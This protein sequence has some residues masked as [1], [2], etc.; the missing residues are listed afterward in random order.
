MFNRAK[1][2]FFAILAITG[3]LALLSW[4]A[5]ALMAQPLNNPEWVTDRAV[6]F[7]VGEEAVRTELARIGKNIDLD[8]L[9]RSAQEELA[10]YSDS[11]L[12]DPYFEMIFITEE[13][14]IREELESIGVILD[15]AS[16]REKAQQAFSEGDRSEGP[17]PLGPGGH[18]GPLICSGPAMAY[19]LYHVSPGSYIGSFAGSNLWLGAGSCSD[20]FGCLVL[21]SA[22]IPPGHFTLTYHALALLTFDFGAWCS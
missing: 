16:L 4:G 8:E 13:E 14:A 2:L 7:V 20:L 5:A 11:S 1:I 6:T 17:T 12:E 10:V 3:L 21:G 15:L 9:M 22:Y 19:N 18:H